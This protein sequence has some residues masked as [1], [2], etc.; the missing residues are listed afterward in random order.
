MGATGWP[1]GVGIPTYRSSP[2][3]GLG[4]RRSGETAYGGTR[5]RTRLRGSASR[6]RGSGGA[7]CYNSAV[8]TEPSDRAAVV[9]S[10]VGRGLGVA[11]RAIGRAAVSAGRS[12]A[13]A[14]RAVDPDVRLHLAEMPLLGL[15]MLAPRSA[16]IA[17]GTD[18]GARP[19]LFV[20][21]LGGHPGNFVAMAT[22]FRLRG[23]TR[24]HAVTLPDDAPDGGSTS[25]DALAQ[26]LRTVV[27]EAA[28]AWGLGEEGRIDVVAHSMGGLVAR[29]ALE[30]PAVA[31]RVATLVTLGTPHAG[32]HA[33]RFG[34]TPRVLDL[35]PGSDVVRRLAERLPW[36]GPPAAPRLVA[37]WSGADMLLLPA[38]TA[39]VEGAENVEL[40][41]VT[42]YGYLIHP[43]AWRRVYAA[44]SRG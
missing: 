30:D 43:E 9:L 5:A 29:L 21:G 23:R 7:A 26:H 36:P 44:L 27:G 39:M 17:P 3:G 42:H 37:L 33:A 10:A 13:S 38:S 25:L 4:A 8:S 24:L 20:H 14:Y 18:D 16:A 19:V 32:T 6:R 11:G 12:V 22:Y 2:M 1:A 28:Q 34:A 31:A 40:P 15:T 35:R 41:G